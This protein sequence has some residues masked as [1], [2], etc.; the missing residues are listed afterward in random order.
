MIVE[1]IFFSYL[2]RVNE[3]RRMRMKQWTL[4]SMLAGTLLAIMPLTIC[5]QML[6][7]EIVSA[8][9]D[10]SLLR[11][12]FDAS[13]AALFLHPAKGF[14][15]ETWFH[16]VNGNVDRQ[17][18]TEDLEAIAASGIA[19]VQ[20]FHGGGF[21]DGWKGVTEPV[22]CLTDKWEDLV[23]H[24]ASEA[25]RLGLRFTL[26]NCPGWAMSGGPWIDL[27]HCMRILACCR[28]DVEGGTLPSS[29]L[30]VT[31]D[32]LDDWR[33]ICVLAFPA[34]LGDTVEPLF[35]GSYSFEPTTADEPHVM[36]MLLDTPATARTLEFCSINAMNHAN[37]VDPHITV[38]VEAV[39]DD[40]EAR[41][42]LSAP[43]PRSN[44]QDAHTLSLPLSEW[45]P[46]RHYRV[47]IVNAHSMNVPSV[48]LFTAA[49]Q[50]NWEAEAGHTLRS[51]FRP[52]GF[53][54]Q[55]SE[56]YVRGN[57][58]IDISDFLDPRDGMLRWQAPEGSRWIVLRIGHVNARRQNGPAPAEAT[59]WECDKL[60][61]KGADTHFAHYVGH[62]AGGPLKGMVSNMLMDSWECYSQ[63]WTATMPDEFMRRSGYALRPW[64]P[65]LFG[66]VI[67]DTETTAR[68]LID[69][70][71]TLNDLYV[72]N[73]FGEMAR[74]AHAAGLTISYET[75]AGDITPA[76][77]MEYY[78]HADVPMCEFWQPFSHWLYN[79]NFKPILPTAS[80]ARMYGKPRVSAEAFTSF[81][82]TWDEHLGMLRDV[83]NQN[84]VDGMTHFVFHTYTHNPGA[85]RYFPG[86]SFGSSI[87]TPFLRGQTWWK[88]MPAFTSCLARSTYMLER[89]MPVS[90]VLWYIGDEPQHKPDQFA[91]FPEGY[92]YDYCNPDALLTRLT[93]VDGEW[94]TPEGI[95][96]PLLWIPERG[97]MLPETLE[98]LVA[99]VRQ[100]GVL[101]ADA[102]TGMATLSDGH[103]QQERYDAAVHT[104][105]PSSGY[106]VRRVGEG[107]VLSGLSI[108]EA[109]AYLDMQPDVQGMANRWVHRR[110]EGADWYFVC[111][112]REQPFDGEVT[113]RCVGSVAQWNT[114]DGSIRPLSVIRVADGCT[115]VSL[116]LAVGESAFIVFT[117]EKNK[118][119]GK[120]FNSR[121]STLHSERLTIESPWTITFPEGW[122]IDAPVVI[123]DLKPW[124]SLNLSD[125][126]RAFA[127]TATYAT[128]FDLPS[129]DRHARYMLHLGKVEMIAVVRL[130][131]VPLGT[132]W[133][134]P[135]DADIT[136]ALRKGSNT[137]EVE[138]T[139][140]WHNR[141]VYD[142]RQPE[143]LRKTWVI[144]GPS[145]NA[146]FRDNGLLGPVFIEMKNE[147]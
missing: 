27:D 72:N 127:G 109:L 47:H 17:G 85:T 52:D 2:R 86:T 20:F 103:R 81:V 59:G 35:S 104:L 121:R 105:W 145:A 80:A 91:A 123:D 32:S 83:A 37:S 7:A 6:T 108:D 63:T 61:P 101:V 54:I 89:G 22:Y 11:R 69:W 129:L 118:P 62:L 43:F 48:R 8:V 132:L 137:L 143:A 40:G 23:R 16:Y 113:F 29:P 65:A 126:G 106:A 3:K 73:F 24:T 100:G 117:D 77:P 93:V 140:S 31:T 95:C 28:L 42:V 36:D 96:Y 25:Q 53:V 10:T 84:L 33:D 4:R 112:D 38:H 70:R 78:K 26:Q 97:R 122:G 66:F 13:D 134:E 119:S 111:A 116:H 88:H 76:D 94:S 138:V 99:L 130:N 142:A 12:P 64:M 107:R 75:A 60:S 79:R 44:W 92:R 50:P 15:P 68:F 56:A 67:D 135:Y 147:K 14:Y 128:T 102:P 136:S 41:T 74:N 141:L 82:L 125:E 120:A 55:S 21:S 98:R 45:K 144:S 131:G 114:V 58:V 90:S 19:G 139:S 146:S 9:P 34:P 46:C 5:G 1:T 115:T 18:I 71:R 51:L 57:A 49:R 133:T 124:C 30:S 110:T 87:G 39:A